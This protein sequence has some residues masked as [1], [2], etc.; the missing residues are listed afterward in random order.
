MHTPPPRPRTHSG[1]DSGERGI[2][3]SSWGWRS[4]CRPRL[5]AC[6]WT[7][8]RPGVLER[9]RTER[10]GG[11]RRLSG[12][13][14]FAGRRLLSADVF[15][16]QMFLVDRRL[17]V[18]TLVGLHWLACAPGSPSISAPPAVEAAGRSPRQDEQLRA[19]LSPSG[20]SHPSWGARC[21]SVGVVGRTVVRPG[22]DQKH[23]STPGPHVI[24]GA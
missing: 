6:R 21:A 8:G 11:R 3:A 23:G 24:C 4:H 16:R 1:S 19:C 9:W 20:P 10:R 7:L 18:C 12:G 14:S 17:R 2:P 22:L 13:A 15:C 5:R